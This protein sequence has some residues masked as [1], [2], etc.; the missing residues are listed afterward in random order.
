MDGLSELL[1]KSDHPGIKFNEKIDGFEASEIYSHEGSIKVETRKIS[2]DD[3]VP[4]LNQRVDDIVR[5]VWIKRDIKTTIDPWED[6]ISKKNQ[7][8]VLKY[9]DLKKAYQLGADGL[10]V[11]LPVE[12]RHGLNKQHFVLGM[13]GHKGILVWTHDFMTNRTEALWNGDHIFLPFSLVRP[14][15]ECQKQLARHPMFLALVAAICISQSTQAMIEPICNKINQVENRTQH[16]PPN[17]LTR[18]TVE[19]NYAA[20]SAMMSGSATH[21]AGFEGRIQNL[22][23]I[24]DSISGYKWPHGLEQPEWAEAVVKD[25]DQCVSILKKRVK[26]QEQRI[27]Y[28]S[29]RADI[30][31]TAVSLRSSLTGKVPERGK[32]YVDFDRLC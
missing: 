22:R 19:G 9:F 14:V 23:D 12:D 32:S 11:C 28:L 4:W 6:D 1:E 7:D 20:L 2:D 29:H 31:L 13:S 8:L 21:L 10:L 5:M 25:V 16:G 30:Q 26:G 3:V 17:L 15:L 24:F 18:P 27:R